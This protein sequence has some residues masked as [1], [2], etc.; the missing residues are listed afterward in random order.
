MW[1]SNVVYLIESLVM[2][3]ITFESEMQVAWQLEAKGESGT[4]MTF[5]TPVVFVATTP[6]PASWELRKRNFLLI[7]KF[8]NHDHFQIVI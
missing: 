5:F 4:L 2:T 6:S 3:E 7:F 1:I 8:T